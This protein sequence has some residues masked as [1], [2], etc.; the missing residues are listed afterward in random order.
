MT[1]KSR[2]T[3]P[4][5]TAMVGLLLLVLS[6]CSAPAAESG[7]GRGLDDR[8]TL[9]KANTEV[10]NAAISLAELNTPPA[11]AAA[12]VLMPSLGID[13]KVEPHGLDADKLMSLPVS[14]FRAGWYKYSPGPASD[15]GATVIAAHVDSLAE[16][17]GPFA[18]LRRAEVGAEVSVVDAAG[19][20][21][22]YRVVSVERIS[23]AEVPLNRVFRKD[24]APVV[25]LVTCGG[26]FD[27]Q[28]DSYKDN[29]IV[30]A[31]KVS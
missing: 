9:P 17:V 15:E 12:R 14:P 8:A 22:D 16:G 28:A 20:R 23:K 25:V 31:E 27:R 1:S 18:Q 19:E 5:T 6:A 4:I 30:T 24:G 11:P 29:Y 21:H 3:A 13:M 2:S 10:Q 7:G 26:E